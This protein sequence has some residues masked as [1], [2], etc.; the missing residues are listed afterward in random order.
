MGTTVM[1]P[2][3]VAKIIRTYAENIYISRHSMSER[4]VER[5][6]HSQEVLFDLAHAFDEFEGIKES[7]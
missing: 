3:D 1:T 2:K 7:E 4:S 5:W 6:E